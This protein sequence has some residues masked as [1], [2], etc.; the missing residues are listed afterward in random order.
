M[1]MDD[2]PEIVRLFVK[3]II[4]QKLKGT[5][6]IQSP[7][8]MIVPGFAILPFIDVTPASKANL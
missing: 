8:L 5:Y 1:A 2:I 7:F 4:S 6:W 3:Q